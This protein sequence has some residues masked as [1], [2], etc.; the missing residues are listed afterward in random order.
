M[1]EMSCSIYFGRMIAIFFGTQNTAYWLEAFNNVPFFLFKVS[2]LLLFFKLNLLSVINVTIFND[3]D[4][5]A[6]SKQFLCYFYL[7]FL[8]YYFVFSFYG[9]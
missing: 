9:I 7:Y 1:L 3:P 2:L 5:T 8:G 4:L 6:S